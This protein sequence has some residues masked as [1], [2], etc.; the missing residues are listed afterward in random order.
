VTLCTFLALL[1]FVT[2]SRD[3]MVVHADGFTF[4]VK[5]PAGWRSDTSGRDANVVFQSGDATIRIRIQKKAYEHIANLLAADMND[6]RKTNP[7]LQVSELMIDHPIYAT[8]SKLAFVP[9]QSYDYVTYLNA[10]PDVP[11]VFSVVMSVPKRP[12]NADEREALD[13]VARSLRCVP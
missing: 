9:R 11:Y 13:A 1:F 6:R 2:P 7:D 4:S 3:P 12:A 10:G 8:Y 5:A